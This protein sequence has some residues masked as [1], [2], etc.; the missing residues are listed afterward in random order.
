MDEDGVSGRAWAGAF[1]ALSP[2]FPGVGV[3]RGSSAGLAGRI[4]ENERVGLRGGGGGGGS[5]GASSP[6]PPSSLLAGKLRSE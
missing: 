5:S 2:P 6:P 1:N 3:M 4:M